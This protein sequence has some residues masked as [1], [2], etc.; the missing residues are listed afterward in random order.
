MHHVIL[1]IHDKPVDAFGRPFVSRT[2]A[3][4]LRT[5][6]IEVNRVAEG[7]MLNS[8]AGDYAIYQVGEWDDETGQI[9]GVDGPPTRV[10]EALHLQKQ[11]SLI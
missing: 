10:A 2:V 11:A 8:H 4:G 6:A 9:K 3:E 7:N 1:A 5:I